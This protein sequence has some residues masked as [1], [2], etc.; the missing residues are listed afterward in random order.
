MVL[1]QLNLEGRGL[2]VAPYSNPLLLKGEHNVAYTDY[3]STEILREKASRNPGAVGR[4]VPAVDFVWSRGVPLSECTNERFDYAVASHVIE[5]APNVIGW[6]N[7]ILSVMRPDAVL[8][9]CVPDKRRTMDYYRRETTLGEL[10]GNW[11]ENRTIPTPA[12]VMDFLSQSFRDVGVRPQPFEQGLVFEQV[13]REYADQQALDFAVFTH[14]ETYYLDV[15]CTVWTPESFVDVFSRLTAL[16]IFAID[17][18]T[19]VENCE[20]DEFIVHLTKRGE[21]SV[22]PPSAKTQPAPQL[23]RSRKH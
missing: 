9:L 8:A 16:G 7:D 12:Q 4:E 13:P 15:H 1:G 23:A 17:I 19:P 6:V 21:P 22:L 5:H 11:I 18:G 10:V 3:A 2:E 14:N 20:R